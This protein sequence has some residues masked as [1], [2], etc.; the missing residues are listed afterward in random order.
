[1]HGNLD[2]KQ[3]YPLISNVVYIVFKEKSK[4]YNNLYICLTRVLTL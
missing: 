1:M 3:T 4:K 2:N